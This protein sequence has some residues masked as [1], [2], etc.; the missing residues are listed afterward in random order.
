MTIYDLIMKQLNFAKQEGL[1]SVFITPDVT[2]LDFSELQ[3]TIVP[4]TRIVSI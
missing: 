2:A 4:I 1:F 3:W